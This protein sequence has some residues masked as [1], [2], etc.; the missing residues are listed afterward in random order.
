MRQAFHRRFSLPLRHTLSSSVEATYSSVGFMPFRW[1]RPEEAG[2]AHGAVFL[3]LTEKTTQNKIKNSYQGQIIQ[4][5]FL[6]RQG[7]VSCFWQVVHTQILRFF[8]FLPKKKFPVFVCLWLKK[9]E[10]EK[11]ASTKK[12]DRTV[13]L[14]LLF[15]AL[16][17]PL[18]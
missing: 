13:F 10:K 11:E 18:L 5:C 3:F 1:P 9:P 12:E 16:L 4:K 14:L 8:F 7:K 15:Q 2:L 17:V 6:L